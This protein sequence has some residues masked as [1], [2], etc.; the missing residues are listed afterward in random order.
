MTIASAPFAQ[1]FWRAALRRFIRQPAAS[2]STGSAG[3]SRV[4]GIGADGGATRAGL[5]SARAVST[6]AR[7]GRFD[8]PT[9]ITANTSANM[10]STT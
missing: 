2:R 9:M 10:G 1:S 5:A 3:F 4:S 6:G 8:S 7:L